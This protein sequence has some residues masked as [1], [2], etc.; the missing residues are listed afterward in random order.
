[1]IGKFACRLVETAGQ[2]SVIRILLDE[3]HHVFAPNRFDD[4]SGE[5]RFA[6]TCS[7]A[8]STIIG[9]FTGWMR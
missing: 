5:S 6:R 1:M 9:N 4:F 2:V 8:N 3:N 7:A